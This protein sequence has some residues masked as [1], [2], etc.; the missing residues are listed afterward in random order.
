MSLSVVKPPEALPEPRRRA[1]RGG[2]VLETVRLDLELVTPVLGGAAVPRTI[3]AVD[4]VRVPSIRGQLR[5]WWRALNVQR[6]VS[7]KKLYE[8][9]SALFGRAADEGGGRSPVELRVVSVA[10]GQKDESEVRLTSGKRGPATPGAY[11]LFPARAEAGG[12][13]TAPRR[14]PGTGFTLELR[15]PKERLE[16]LRHVLRAW[17]LF[18]GYGSRTRRGLGGLALVRDRELWLPREASLAEFGR[19]FGRDVF[20]PQA[21]PAELAQTPRLAGAS[22]LVGKALSPADLDFKDRVMTEAERAW[23]TALHWLR[24]FR[25][26]TDTG[27]REPGAGNR[28]SISNWPEADKIRHL[29]GKTRSHE[30]RYGPDPAWP[31]AA[32]GL[33]IVGQFQKKA[34]DGGT[35]DEPDPFELTWKDR[36][37]L[38]NRLASPLIVKAMP[39]A[40]GQF[41]PI[42]LWLARDWPPHGRVVLRKNKT[43]DVPKSAAPFD[44]LL[45]E[46]DP[47]LFPPLRGKTSLR[48]AFLDWLASEKKA[49]RIA[50]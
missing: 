34:R 18:G 14:K 16:E 49:T 44:K 7:A 45:S 9:E 28:P 6:Y 11:A 22:L 1:V 42:A 8:A 19:L 13:P 33:P 20:A 36:E 26:E 35:Y 3:D 50:G 2:P 32:F 39:L 43:E 23:L 46:K 17:I 37:G 41:V 48:A 10:P 27:A 38:H 15:A 12:T 24:D 5:F 47:V 40:D 25:Q 29:T 21:V 31:R 4:I 30:P